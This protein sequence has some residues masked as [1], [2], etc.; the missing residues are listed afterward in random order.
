MTNEGSIDTGVIATGGGT[1]K[2]F[3]ANGIFAQSVGGGG[4]SGGSSSGSFAVGGQGGGG[5]AAGAVSVTH[6]GDHITTQGEQ[7]SAIFAQSVG[8]GGG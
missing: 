6:S 5:G 4:G 1:T 3:G 2:G 8:G 7:A